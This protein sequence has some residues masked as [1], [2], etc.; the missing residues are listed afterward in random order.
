MAG[1]RIGVTPEKGERDSWH[2]MRAGVRAID[3]E[4]GVAQV[5]V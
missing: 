1:T 4:R 2:E 3:R 5:T